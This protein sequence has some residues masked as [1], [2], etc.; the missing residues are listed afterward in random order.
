VADVKIGT[1][2]MTVKLIHPAQRETIGHPFGHVNWDM[3][4]FICFAFAHNPIAINKSGKTRV[5]LTDR[6]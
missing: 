1:N 4:S 2:F 6:L 3:R 5:L